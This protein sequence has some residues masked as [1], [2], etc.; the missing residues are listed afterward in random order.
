MTMVPDELNSALDRFHIALMQWLD[1]GGGER[2]KT[3]SPL[4]S[5]RDV[6]HIMA[7]LT[8]NATESLGVDSDG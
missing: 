7:D 8:R 1:S 6:T 5:W 4:K 2:L 3:F